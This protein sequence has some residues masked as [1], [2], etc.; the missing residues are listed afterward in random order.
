MIHR[1]TD[2][3]VNAMSNDEVRQTLKETVKRLEFVENRF[4]HIHV[5]SKTA[6]IFAK[7]AVLICEIRFMRE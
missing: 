5:N 2:E 7:S 1:P 4:R 6:Q 3:Q